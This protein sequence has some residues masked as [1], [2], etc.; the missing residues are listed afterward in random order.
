MGANIATGIYNTIFSSDAASKIGRTQAAVIG[1]QTEVQA[2]TSEFNTKVADQQ[3]KMASD[4]AAIDARD[5]RSTLGYKVASARALSA[6][7]GF[8]ILEGS[9]MMVDQDTMARIEFGASRIGYG[10]MLE[11]SRLRNQAALA[12]TSADWTRKYGALAQ[13]AAVQA[14]DAKASAYR[15][16]GYGD[17]F[18]NVSLLGTSLAGRDTVWGSPRSGS[19]SRLNINPDFYPAL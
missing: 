2:Q 13:D 5:F 1:A 4:K 6:N 7:S 3:A 8:D 19:Q 9:P 16:S 10:G 15:M 11:S 14:G 18:K 12:R 17:I